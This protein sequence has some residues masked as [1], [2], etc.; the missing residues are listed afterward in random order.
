MSDLRVDWATHKAALLACQRWH[1]TRS[2]PPP[3][4]VH[5]GVW[6]GGKFI[7]VVLFSR[8]ASASLLSPWGLAQT[9]GCELTRIALAQHEAPV[10]RIVALA[11][12]FLR[13]S[14]P[15]LR[16][17]VSFADPSQGHV[18]GIYQA[19]NWLYTGQSDPGAKYIE[20]ATGREWHA[21]MVSKTGQK[22][23]F[24]KMRSVVNAADC[25][26]IVTPGKHRYLMPLDDQMKQR[27]GAV[28][29]PYPRRAT[30]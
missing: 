8:G 20:R 14:N 23:V 9:E 6:E 15:G 22:R 16:L 7:G 1:Y 17:I 4:M 29:K 26:K 12:R 28:S 3:P 18:G 13:K 11:I 2:L 27:L 30:D 25:D 5:V 19:G 21:R 10:S 24:G